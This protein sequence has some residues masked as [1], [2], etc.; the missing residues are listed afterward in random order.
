M[1]KLRQTTDKVE[2][3]RK[4][5]TGD[6]HR[7]LYHFVPP[8]NWMND[9]NGFIHWQGRYHLFYQYNPDGAYHNN[10]HWGHAA[11][12]DLVHWED[13]PVAL[14][15][16][17]DGPDADGCWSGSAVISNGQP[18]IFYSGVHPQ[19][20]CVAFGSDDLNVWTKHPGNP[21]IAAPPPEIDAGH[22]ADFR[23]PYVWHD[24]EWW[25]MVMGSRH[26]GVGGVVLLYRSAD[27]MAWEYVRPLLVGDQTAFEPFWT[28]SVWEC[29]NLIPVGGRHVLIVSYQN[30]DTGHLLF[31][32]YYVGHFFDDQFMAGEPKVLEYGGYLYAPQAIVDEKGRSLL[33]G[34]LLEGRSKEAQLAAGW[35]GVMSLPRVLSLGDDGALCMRPVPEL[36]QLRRAHFRAEPGIVRPD[37]GNM[38]AETRGDC[39]EIE[40]LLEP[41]QATAFGL[42]LRRS[43]D[44]AEKTTLRCDMVAG[45]VSLDRRRSSLDSDGDTRKQSGLALAGIENAPL[46]NNGPVRLHVFLDRSVLEVF[47]NDRVVLSSRI[48]PSRPDS[49]GVELF[50]EGGMIRVHSLDVWQLASIWPT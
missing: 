3:N 38:L 42:H 27:L 40:A 19:T 9:P 31:P 18:V 4:T 15:P 36:R 21:L 5:L 10:I 2:V 29:P 48:Y 25:Y 1:D 50:T 28:G 43:P 13:R 44:G 22:P 8:A 41:Y 6:I 7:P 39:L 33:L 12:H 23:D 46:E 14:A 37:Q 17:P 30:F 35:S 20:V 47:V 24:G 26:N 16:T 32:G 34:W 49:L 11:S 45:I